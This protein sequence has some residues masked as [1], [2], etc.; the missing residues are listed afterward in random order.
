[1]IKR[2]LY[3]GNPV[4]LSKKDNQMLIEFPGKDHKDPVSVPIEDIGIVILDNAQLTL[5][6]ALLSAL[7]QNC[8]AVIGCDEKH[9]PNSLMLPIHAHHAFTEKLY[10]QIDSSL[11]LRKNLGNKPS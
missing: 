4:C 8:T 2:T 7:Q 6:N 5:S 3:F 11:P 1:M 9:L 10:H